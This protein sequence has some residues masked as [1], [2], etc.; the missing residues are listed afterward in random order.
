MGSTPDARFIAD[1]W[2]ATLARALHDADAQAVA[3]TFLPTGWLRD[4]LTFTWDTRSLRGRDAIARYLAGSDRLTAARIASVA[5]DTDPFYAPRD[6]F[7][8]SGHKVGV[9][10][11]FTYET[12]Y[13]L[14]RGYAHLC[15]APDGTWLA[16]TVGM[17][18][19]DLKAHPE[20]R[21]VAADWETN[22]RTWA[23]YMAEQ[24]ARNES[25]PYVLIVGAGQ[26][27]LSAAA[28]FRQMDIPTLIIEKN[29]SI[30]ESWRTRYES[31][32]L[33][34][35]AFYCPLLYQP[36]PSDWPDYLPK[37]KVADWL[38]SY[39]A[40][41]HLTI[42]TK[43]VL[44]NQPSYDESTRTWEVVVD[45][46]GT[47]VVLRPKHIVL[48]TGMLGAPR[49]PD[50]PGR[51]SFAGTVM[52]A[53]GF[54]TPAPFAGQRV[55][56][57]GAGNSSIDICQDL[58]SG[59]AP[60]A[61]VTMVQRSR[62]CVVSRSSVREDLVHNWAPGA[63]VDV[64]D[65][66]FAAQPLGWFKELFQSMPDALWAREKVLHDKLRKGGLELFLGPEGGGQLLMVFER[67]GGYWLDKGGADLIADGRIKIKKGAAPIAFTPSGLLFD[68]GSELHADAV[69]FATGYDRIRDVHTR[70]FGKDV[71]DRM[72]EAWGL[73]S[74]GEVKGC[75]RPT[76]HPALW[77]AIGDFFN[78]RFMSK[79]LVSREQSR[80]NEGI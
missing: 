7:A 15:Q 46:D 36:Y 13:V 34:T 68:D 26:N 17:L 76:G 54:R 75:Y 42:W 56:V 4:V 45:R 52:H 65:F 3:A 63:P 30:G 20:Q 2:V 50:L 9:E 8:P 55:V 64:G 38:E 29:A 25:A 48:A 33:H 28:R 80:K 31:L 67:N 18:A 49:L 74:E 41:Q 71:V 44:A 11:G 47:Q 39:A 1:N 77:Y 66:K 61:S 62:T 22:G 35:P 69:V 12:R 53:A 43:S 14:G 58:A 72:G 24:R 37:D 60:A 70:T 51:S 79:Q 27:G 6:S 21:D 78:C 19:L 23:E 32:T 73:D 59:A 10:T 57:V 40:H 16:V 5:V